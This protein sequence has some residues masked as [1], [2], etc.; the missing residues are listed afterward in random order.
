MSEHLKMGLLGGGYKQ[1][2]DDAPTGMDGGREAGA[3]GGRIWETIASL[4]AELNEFSG[5]ISELASLHS[6]MIS[7][8]D[9]SNLTSNQSTLNSKLRQTAGELSNKIRRLADD[10]ETRTSQALINQSK[11]LSERHRGLLGEWQEEERR[12]RGKV[13]ERGERQLRIVKPDATDDQVRQALDAGVEG[14]IFSQA[15]LSGARHSEARGAFRAVQERQEEIRKIER[16]L[17]ELAT[18]FS[19]MSMLVN[20]QDEVLQVIE[21]NAETSYQDMEQ[22]VNHLDRGV[23]TAKKTRSK[24][25]LC[26]WISLAIVLVLMIIILIVLAQMGV[27]KKK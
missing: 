8:P 1:L 5:S 24:R 14:Q 16:T 10:N 13:R 23:E 7:S 27:F 12:W 25:W 9:N 2:G 6:Q 15:L 26:L 11:A 17:E 20:R 4:R 19:D 18:M 21:K 3:S 22:G